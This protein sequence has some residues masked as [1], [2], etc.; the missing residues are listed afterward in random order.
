LTVVDVQTVLRHRHLTSTQRY[1]RP[2]IDDVI[3]KLHGHLD[4]PQPPPRPAP[5]YAA[6]DLQVVF[7]G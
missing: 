4:R 3:D 1:F 6:E 5:G 7:G 2:R